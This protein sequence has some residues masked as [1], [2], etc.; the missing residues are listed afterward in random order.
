[1]QPIN[2]VVVWL[3]CGCE[4]MKEKETH[5]TPFLATH[6]AHDFH[7]NTLIVF[8]ASQLFVLYFCFLTKWKKGF[9]CAHTRNFFFSHLCAM[10]GYTL[11]VFFSFFFWFSAREWRVYLT[12]HWIHHTHRYTYVCGSACLFEINGLHEILISMNYQLICWWMQTNEAVTLKSSK[13][14][15]RTNLAVTKFI[16]VQN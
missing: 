12:F 10:M 11:L 5:G 16:G 13:M 9:V 15:L 8:T 4:T 7:A 1:M 6:T 2:V 14:Q 3:W